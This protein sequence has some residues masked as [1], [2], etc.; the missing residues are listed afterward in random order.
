MN[1]IQMLRKAA[2]HYGRKIAIVFGKLRLSY[3]SLEEASNK[4]AQSLIKLGVSKG[5]RVAILLTNCPEFVVTYFGIIKTGAIAVPLDI[6]YKVKELASLFDNCQPKVLVSDDPFLEPLV[7]HLPRF[8][9]IKQVI[10]LGSKYRDRCLSYRDI[11]AKKLSQIVESRVKPEDVA[12]IAYTSG[13]AFRPK[14]VMLSH[15]NLVTSAGLSGEA[16]QQTDKDITTLFALP[17]HHAFGLVVVL[18]AT[19]AKGGTVA[20][21]P[22]L[23]I[24]S[25]FE[26]IEREKATTFWG[27]P[28]VFSLLTRAA[29][30]E[31]LNRDLSSLRLC[32]SAG[33]SLPPD[34]AKRFKQVIGPDVIELW[35]LTEAVGCVT[36]QP[37]DEKGKL[38]S[39]GKVLPGYEVKVVDD[40]GRE[41]PTGQAG[42]VIFRGPMMQ[43]YYH[44]PQ[45]TAAT[46][47]GGWLHTGDIGKFD[48][49]GELSIVGRKR[50]M[51]ISKGQNIFPSDIE[52]VLNAHPKIAQSAVVGVPDETRGEVVRA[53][54][55]LKPGKST[56][57]RKIIRY[58]QNHLANYKL[59]KQIIFMDSLP[60]TAS[61]SIQKEEL[62]KLHYP[63]L[64]PA[65]NRAS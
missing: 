50:E 10:N 11:V 46:I 62:S 26:L 59:P 51:I 49:D 27:V 52:D 54:I 30:E 41:L 44:N 7:S 42:E 45:A 12:H 37:I 13:P 61:G 23:S 56:T 64:S 40:D 17:L 33:A 29:E 36:A 24:S 4:V 43:G 22:G 19:L 34:T 48:Q 14:G 16:F 55:S 63:Y 47:R 5:D 53:A 32:V 6:K 15:Q 28:F 20:I 57:E 18:F 60:K 1:L 8:K 3:A 65:I 21:M 58:C 2:E 35:G 9:Y 39:V 31:G 25:L 38:S